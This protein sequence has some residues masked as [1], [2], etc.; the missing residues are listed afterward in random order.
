MWLVVS[1]TMWLVVSNSMYCFVFDDVTSGLTTP[2]CSLNAH[3]SSV[4]NRFF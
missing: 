1:N 3:I 2:R 4:S